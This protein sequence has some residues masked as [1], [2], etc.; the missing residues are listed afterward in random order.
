MNVLLAASDNNRDHGAFLSMMKLAELLEKK[1]KHRVVIVVPYEGNGTELIKAGGFRYYIIPSYNWV[2]QLKEAGNIKVSIKAA[3]KRLCN[4]GSIYRISR[5]IKEEKIDLV[6]INTSWCYVGAK[7][8]LQ[9]Q[10][11]LVWHIREFLEED[12]GL[13]IWHRNSGYK[14][15]NRADC[16][17]A[18]SNSIKDKYSEKLKRD[19][20]KVVLNGIDPS[21]Y[22]DQR[23]NIFREEEATFLI[24]GRVCEGKGQKDV[25]KACIKLCE[26]G[27]R[28]FS[29]QIVGYSETEYADELKKM[30]KA[31]G[32]QEQI[33]F[34][35][36]TDHPE[37]YYKNADITFMSS[38]SEAF[39]RVTVEAMLGGSLVIGAQSAGTAEIITDNETGLLYRT[40]DVQD[41]VNKIKYAL[42]NK[43]QARQIAKNG[44]TIA[45]NKFSAERNADEINLIYSNLCGKKI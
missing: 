40:G 12:Q 8:A 21:V 44:Q 23:H 43:K 38:V 28:N 31:S 25:V 3:I 42:E 29:L 13:T 14:L 24:V 34:A 10:K 19:I 27:I 39:G 33:L 6:H 9:N 30:I 11:P 22:L 41:L 15:F 5:I 37:Q 2:I 36:I 20:I 45:M 35:G 1:H 18:I 32:C 7:A 4:T 17:I 16:I 26:E